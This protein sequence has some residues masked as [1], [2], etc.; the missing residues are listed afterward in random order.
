VKKAKKGSDPPRG[1][2]R[3]VSLAAAI[4]NHSDDDRGEHDTWWWWMERKTGQIIMFPDASNSRYGSFGD[5]AIILL[6]FRV[7]IRKYLVEMRAHKTSQTFVNI[8]KNLYELLD[9]LPTLTKL[10]VMA[11]YTQA[12]SRPLMAYVRS[13]INDNSLLMGPIYEC[14]KSH[15]QAIADAPDLVLSSNASPK[16]GSVFGTEVWDMLEIMY[17][18]QALRQQEKLPN[19]EPLFIAFARGAS[20]TMERFTKEYVPDSV[21]ASLTPSRQRRGRCTLVNDENEGAL[22]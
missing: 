3:A 4:L 5:S 1:V 22:A 2:I 6:L 20:K 10:A 15:A 12:I 16:T 18:I 11:L 19:L 14:V 21:I 13:H 17:G 7:E 9:D 8:Q